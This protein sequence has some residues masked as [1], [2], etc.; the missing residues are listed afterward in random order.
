MMMEMMMKGSFFWTIA[1]LVQFCDGF[2]G[3][4]KGILTF[5]LRVGIDGFGD[6][7]H[8]KRWDY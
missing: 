1:L 7:V 3:H 8:N 2:A 5:V 6:D 4:K